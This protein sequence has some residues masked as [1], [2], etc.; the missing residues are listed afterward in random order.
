MTPYEITSTG[1][2]S[3]LSRNLATCWPTSEDLLGTSV[4]LLVP[5]VRILMELQLVLQHAGT[6]HFLQH[7][8]S[9]LFLHSGVPNFLSTSHNH[10]VVF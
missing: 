8:T 4:I 7:H 5:D 9:M 10:V 3:K 2:F 1:I 6:P